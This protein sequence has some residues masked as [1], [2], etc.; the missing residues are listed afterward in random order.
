MNPSAQ[1][2]PFV[3][4]GLFA[5]LNDMVEQNGLKG[6]FQEGILNWYTFNNNIYALPDGNNIG[7]VYYNKDLFK[8]AGVEVPKTFE[9]MVT[10]VKQSKAKA[11]SQW[12]SVKKIPGRVRSCS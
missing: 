8:Q 2:K 3:D 11:F 5:P 12:L 6:T 9:E 4:A 7:L 10:A 1:M